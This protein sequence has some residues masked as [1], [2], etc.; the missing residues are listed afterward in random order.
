MKKMMTIKN[1]KLEE[2]TN[3]DKIIEQMI[4]K[5]KKRSKKRIKLMKN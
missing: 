2:N 5:K 3:C 4:F 1:R